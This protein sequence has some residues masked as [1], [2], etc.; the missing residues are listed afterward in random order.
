MRKVVLKSTLNTRDLGGYLLNS[1]DKTLERAFIR[2]DAPL[3]L[4]EEDINVLLENN[5]KTIIDLR[6][7]NEANRKPYTIM[8]HKEF[9]YYH[10]EIF[11]GG[12][13]PESGKLVPISYFDMIDEQKSIYNVMKILANAKEGV[14][15]HCAVGKDRTGVISALLL[16]L[17]DARREEIIIDYT[18][19]W[20]RLKKELIEYCNR[21]ESV[22]LD[23][24]TPKREYIEQFLDMF[25]KK[26]NNVE[27]YLK[28]IG[29]E[30]NE[31]LMLK[32]KLKK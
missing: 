2:S 14:I 23:I 8:K 19:S 17:A 15:Y 32:Q 13:V 11:G 6:S 20:D 21:C 31:I 28:K 5:I 30:E 10:C 9:N 1:G 22:N 12:K 3:N 29:L 25:H 16:L 7:D 4:S 18:T 24:V 26:Y 27:E